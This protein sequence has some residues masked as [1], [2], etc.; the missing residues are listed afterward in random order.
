[1]EP[2][3]FGNKQRC[4]IP[5]QAAKT[6]KSSNPEKTHQCPCQIKSVLFVKHE[7]IT[8]V[9]SRHFSNRVGLD[10]TLYVCF[11]RPNIHPWA[12]THDSGK[13]STTT[14]SQ[15]AGLR[16][17]YRLLRTWEGKKLMES[18]QSHTPPKDTAQQWTA[19]HTTLGREEETA[20]RAQHPHLATVRTVTRGRFFAGLPPGT[21]VI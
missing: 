15:M 5:F 18:L 4:K 9:I 12:S 3:T 1:M 19:A 20:I 11:Q 7:I 14:V 10:C 13:R 2:D 6:Q 16:E 17:T 8:E 21:K